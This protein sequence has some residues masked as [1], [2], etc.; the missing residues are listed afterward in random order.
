[1]KNTSKG[2]RAPLIFGACVLALTVIL[3][4]V[5]LVFT[6]RGIDSVTGYYTT[7]VGTFVS[8]YLPLICVAAMA[9]LCFVPKLYTAQ[10]DTKNTLSVKL[11]SVVAAAGFAIY[12]F[13]CVES[14]VL[15]H[16]LTKL[17]MIA[18]IASLFGVAFFIMIAFLKDLDSPVYLI[19]GILVIVFG[20][21][22][23]ASSYFDL[24]TPMNSPLKILNELGSLAL[25]LLILSELRAVF[26]TKRRQ[27]Q[28]FSVGTAVL[29]LG[30]SSIPS[31]VG[32]F[33][34]QLPYTYSMSANDT[35]LATAFVFAVARLI[36]LCFKHKVYVPLEDDVQEAVASDNQE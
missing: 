1:M 34:G 14:Y 28:L 13:K 18:L 17:E 30:V 27:L 7:W 5:R 15:Y 22:N 23:I 6:L 25:M 16:T 33:C 29:I 9:V 4:A 12:T 2:A 21:V 19:C 8:L 31:L 26:D 36:Q 11:A 32:Y 35:V 10:A 24:L 20:I 3:T